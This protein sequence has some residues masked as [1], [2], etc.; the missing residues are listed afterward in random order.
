LVQLEA[1]AV[2][3]VDAALKTALAADAPSTD[4]LEQDFF[5]DMEGIPT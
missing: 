2:T 3:E 4:E 1:D 5:V